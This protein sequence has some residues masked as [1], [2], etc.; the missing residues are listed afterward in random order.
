MPASTSGAVQ[1]SRANVNKN[2]D[3]DDDGDEVSG[4]RKADS[5]KLAAKCTCKLSNM[6]L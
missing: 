4:P 5:I 1:N 6:T 3:D 2:N